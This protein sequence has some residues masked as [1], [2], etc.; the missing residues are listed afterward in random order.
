MIGGE[1]PVM[2]DRGVA[3]EL[4]QRGGV[5][6][7]GIGALL[8]VVLDDGRARTGG[9]VDDDAGMGRRSGMIRRGDVHD[10]QRRLH[11]RGDPEIQ[12]IHEQ[13]G[14]EQPEAPDVAVRQGLQQMRYQLLIR[15]GY[16]PQA[17]DFHP[18]D[19]QIHALRQNRESVHHE[20]RRGA[21]ILAQQAQLRGRQERP[22]RRARCVHIALRGQFAQI[23]IA[24]ALVVQGRQAEPQEPFH[25]L[26]AQRRQRVGVAR[27]PLRLE[28]SKGGRGRRGGSLQRRAHAT[29]A[30]CTQSYPR[31][32]S[33]SASERSPDIRIRPPDRT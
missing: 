20:H 14:V 4:D 12:P 7:R 11:P 32:S 8:N 15:A 22:G 31:R 26:L 18:V 3:F 6:K 24:P 5:A 23:R 28:G 33:S 30:P 17:V 29:W 19:E 13:R 25:R 16:F 21:L 9:G 1:H 10:D 27:E 2:L